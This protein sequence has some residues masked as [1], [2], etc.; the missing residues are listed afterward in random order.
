MRSRLPS[1]RKRLVRRSKRSIPLQTWSPPWCAAERRSVGGSTS[2]F[3]CQPFS[4]EQKSVRRLKPAS[5]PTFSLSWRRLPSTEA[6]ERDK[7]TADFRG[8]FLPEVSDCLSGVS[9]LDR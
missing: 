2:K 4:G 1:L 8:D 5:S 9:E 3:R 7:A 6:D